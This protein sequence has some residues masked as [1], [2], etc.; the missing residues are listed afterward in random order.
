MQGQMHGENQAQGSGTEGR[1]NEGEPPTRAYDVK[2]ARLTT[3]TKPLL[4]GGDGDG[5]GK[6]G[7]VE[8]GSEEDEAGSFVGDKNENGVP[9]ADRVRGQ[10]KMMAEHVQG[11]IHE[12]AVKIRNL[13]NK[14]NIEEFDA[15][16]VEIKQKLAECT[17]PDA[18]KRQM[19][20]FQNSLKKLAEKIKDEDTKQ[21]A[22]RVFDQ[23]KGKVKEV[24]DEEQYEALAKSL[25]AVKRTAEAVGHKAV[26]F[27][28]RSAETI[29][30][31][32]EHP[33][34]AKDIAREVSHRLHE[35]TKK[36]GEF[37][38]EKF[39]E[40]RHM[41]SKELK[42]NGLKIIEKGRDL[43]E[44]AADKY[45]KMTT[46]RA[47]I[48]SRIHNLKTGFKNVL[49]HEIEGGVTD[50][51]TMEVS[52]HKNL[53]ELK[54]EILVPA[55]LTP[56]ILTLSQNTNI[57][58]LLNLPV[59]I[60]YMVVLGIEWD[61][62]CF[63]TDKL[64]MQQTFVF[65]TFFDSMYLLPSI[66][67]YA[68]IEKLKKE[69][70]AMK[71]MEPIDK[72]DHDDYH[73]TKHGDI[74]EEFT[75]RPHIIRLN[76]F[77]AVCLLE[78]YD[79]YLSSYLRHFRDFWGVIA[80]MYDLA[81]V[82][83]FQRYDTLNCE[84]CDELRL[85]QIMS[86]IASIYLLTFLFRLII[87]LTAFLCLVAHMPCVKRYLI[88][89]ARKFDHDTGLRVAEFA[90]RNLIYRKP[91]KEMRA[92]KQREEAKKKSKF[93]KRRRELLKELRE[94]D[95]KLGLN[96]DELL[97]DLRKDLRKQG[98]KLVAAGVKISQEVSKRFENSKD[99]GGGK[100]G[101]HVA[102][103]AN[104]SDRVEEKSVGDRRS[105]LTVPVRESAMIAAVEETDNF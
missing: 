23:A 14:D 89:M 12:F 41:D 55:L 94:I 71:K 3:T 74:F 48:S 29:K 36:A 34:E 75:G 53:E 38:K 92:R 47:I 37:A 83:V 46:L 15:K 103:D 16:V 60:S 39:E 77:Q 63:L 7:N 2:R 56:W 27:A 59:W 95:G 20:R 96:S 5:R 22:R 61:R 78:G 42:E 104:P 62:E 87:G 68:W 10:A 79:E 45:A 25:K 32:R 11:V 99:D 73:D 88:K 40:L 9:V 19:K 76:T 97:T 24:L 17:H 69:R 82:I 44:T 105:S 98:E 70:K 81:F 43:I 1:L 84:V 6:T 28:R 80:N 100:N 91:L 13:S 54:P 4:G 8:R 33:E 35:T 86:F 31:L 21:K 66:V 67:L 101:G 52:H 72:D 57:M 51:Y 90:V 18:I 65:K 85:F 30:H 64:T 49:L 26:R 58:W 102:K 50:V 93:L